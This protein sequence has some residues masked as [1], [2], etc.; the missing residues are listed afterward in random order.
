MCNLPL[1]D[2]SIDGYISLGVVEHFRS[3]VEV[4]KAFKEC[5]RVLKKGGR[6]LITIPN[7]FVP[8]RNRFTLRISRDRIG[9]F[10]KAYS[11]NDVMTL[12]Q[13]IAPRARMT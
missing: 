4:I 2:E 5:R 10:H 3:T 8:L 6:A 11:I 9:M 13:I 7:I 12:G 1:R